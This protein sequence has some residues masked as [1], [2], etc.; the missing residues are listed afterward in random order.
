MAKKGTIT[1]EGTDIRL[2]GQGEDDYISLT[3]ID[4]R[5]EGGGRH[6]ENWMRNQN[7]VEYLA[8]WETLHN[9]GFNSMQLHGIREQIGINRFLLSA[10]KWIEMTNAIGIKSSAGRYGGTFAHPDIA[11]HFCLWLSPTFQLYVAKE[12][13]KLKKEEA[14][15]QKLSL[16][17]TLKRAISKINFKVHTDAIKTHLIPPRILDAKQSGYVY[18]SEADML[19]LALFGVTA[20]QWQ[21]INPT[22]KG[23]I[24]DYATA[25]QLLVLANLENLNAHLI[26]EGIVQDLRLSKLN[27]VAIYQME[28]LSD[29]KILGSLKQLPDK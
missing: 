12:F 29:S 18:A 26:K 10:K 24:R 20:K 15:Q 19:N 22:L 13:Q 23:N 25:E 5:F 28:L 6:I 27:E 8:T 14:E 11:F 4:Q 9:T 16:D 1:V 7:T 17:W 21:G 3:D 2:V